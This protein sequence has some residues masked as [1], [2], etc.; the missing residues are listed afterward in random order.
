MN[1]NQSSFLKKLPKKFQFLLPWK[2]QSSQ[3]KSKILEQER[4]AALKD[5]FLTTVSH[6]MRTPLTILKGALSNLKMGVLGDLTDKQMR[7]IDIANANIDRLS[8]II[9][10]LLDLSRLESGKA[11]V[12]MKAVSLA[13]IIR[14]QVSHLSLLPNER[15]I[16]VKVELPENLPMATADSDLM[17]QV[18][19]N[20]LANAWRFAKSA[21]L[22]R[23]IFPSQAESPDT[24]LWIEMI[25][26]ND[27]PQVPVDRIKSLFAKF[28][29]LGRVSGGEGYKGTGL[30][31]AI[32][33][34]ILE[35]HGGQIWV[36]NSQMGPEFHFT[37][38]VCDVAQNLVRQVQHGIEESLAVGET[39]SLIA[40]K[41]SLADPRLW[42]I[43]R[44]R[45]LRSTDTM[46]LTDKESCSVILARTGSQGVQRM[47]TRLKKV[48][49]E[50]LVGLDADQTAVT[51]GCATYPESS[52]TAEGLVEVAVSGV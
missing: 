31:L 21:I 49:D 51:Y 39:L 34:Q 30:G 45:V 52:Q 37:I 43:I 38:P 2:R 50:E 24:G 3:L 6:E 15:N 1:H 27:G 16:Q 17:Q 26:H 5:E 23:S 33:K 28:V 20:L 40:V 42:G 22:I 13:D 46:E 41:S 48:L 18:M 9:H 7:V 25:I 10:D 14:E 47:L 44:K 8:R 32:C 4:L 12:H 35:Q 36:E 19:T 29:Q 11:K